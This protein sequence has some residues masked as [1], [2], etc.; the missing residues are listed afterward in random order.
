N[1][2]ER[3]KRPRRGDA[4]APFQCEA[5]HARIVSMIHGDDL[6]GLAAAC[7]AAACFDGAIAF[8]ALE[9]RDLPH[10]EAMRF[11]M[12]A[13]LIRRPRWALASGLAVLGWP[14]QLLAFSLA[15]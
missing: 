5:T 2:R 3:R 8:Q 14:F 13:R 15:S 12:L 6:A 10:E 11:S 7:A 9:A 1:R 4:Q